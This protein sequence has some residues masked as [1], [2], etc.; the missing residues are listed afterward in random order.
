[1]IKLKDDFEISV[2]VSIYTK[3]CGQDDTWQ[4]GDPSA[5]IADKG[6]KSLRLRMVD[7]SKPYADELNTDPSITY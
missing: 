7:P 1:M 2:W 6:I 3:N 4:D 5:E